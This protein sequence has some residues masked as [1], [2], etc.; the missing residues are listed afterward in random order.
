MLMDC[1]QQL[2]M[3]KIRDCIQF[4]PIKFIVMHLVFTYMYGSREYNDLRFNTFIQYGYI[5]QSQCLNP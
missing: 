3:V 1:T 4:I 5:R 2:A